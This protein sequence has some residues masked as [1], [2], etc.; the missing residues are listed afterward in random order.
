MIPNINYKLKN[1]S[2]PICKI[3]SNMKS[4]KKLCKNINVKY[5]YIENINEVD[6][7]FIKIIKPVILNNKTGLYEINLN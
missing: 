2:S 7:N 4:F 1:P 5:V 3:K 6:K